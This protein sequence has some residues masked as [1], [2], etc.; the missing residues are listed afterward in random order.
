MNRTR[1]DVTCGPLEGSGSSARVTGAGQ[2]VSIFD[3][4]RQ[5][6]KDLTRSHHDLAA[7]AVDPKFP[8]PP[9]G[10]WPVYVPGDES[11]SRVRDQL[12]KR[13]SDAEIQKIDLRLLPQDPR[14]IRA[15]GLLYLPQPYVVPGG[16][17][18]EM[19]GWDSYFIQM[20]LLRDDQVELA[21]NMADNAL[22]EVREYGKVLNA[23][24]TYYLTRSQPPFLT[25]MILASYRQ[26]Q[27]RT[28]LEGSVSANREILFAL[29]Y[30]PA[31]DPG[32]GI[33]ALLRSRRGSLP[34]GSLL[35]TRF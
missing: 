16:R 25:Q 35:R 26:T 14:Q 11:L 19:Y 17:F 1:R 18:N 23:N 13:M 20:G 10:R 30:G 31:L 21:K 3:Y 9:D 34:R 5:T 2:L 12:R 27:D 32:D 6:W 24:R 29:D 15:Q 22:Y 4:V 8:V 28:W 33:V 7:A